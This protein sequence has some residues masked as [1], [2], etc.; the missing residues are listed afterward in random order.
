[1]LAVAPPPSTGLLDQARTC[2]GATD[3]PPAV[4]GFWNELELNCWSRLNVPVAVTPVVPIVHSGIVPVPS[5]VLPAFGPRD[6]VPFANVIEIVWLERI[7]S[8]PS[9]RQRFLPAS[10]CARV[11]VMASLEITVTVPEPVF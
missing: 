5:Q 9:T 10:N 3:Q 11:T 8:V 7:V 4:A 6:S 2:V 1:M